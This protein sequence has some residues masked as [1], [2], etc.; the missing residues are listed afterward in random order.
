MEIP[1][2]ELIEWMES[3]PYFIE[4]DDFIA[5]HASFDPAKDKFSETD[6]A[7]MISSRYFNTKTHAM[8]SSKK[9]P[10]F[11]LKAWYHAYPAEKLNHKITVFG[12][13]AQPLPRVYKNFR[14]LDTGCCYGGHLS[15]LILPD[16]KIVK[17]P[18]LQTKKFNY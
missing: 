9:N 8:I 2:S 13:W 11:P 6:K 12:H 17:T 14:C 18:S 16:D 15:C 1:K 3:M 7:D 4:G 5:V 10:R